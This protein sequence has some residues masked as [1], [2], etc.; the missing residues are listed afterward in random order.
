MQILIVPLHFHREPLI[1]DIHRMHEVCHVS[2][3]HFLLQMRNMYICIILRPKTA[4]VY[5][6]SY[7][8]IPWGL[9]VIRLSINPKDTRWKKENKRCHINFSHSYWIFKKG[10]G[11]VCFGFV[12]NYV[13][14]FKSN[15]QDTKICLEVQSQC[16]EPTTL[17]L[18]WH[19]WQTAKC[20]RF[21]T[22]YMVL[23]SGAKL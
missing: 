23:K 5:F 20:Q 21:L 2:R 15:W 19:K 9:V 22:W 6:V 8:H 11:L 3:V 1:G 17:T 18:I 16:N 4:N 10:L 13:F 7:F 14:C 12:T